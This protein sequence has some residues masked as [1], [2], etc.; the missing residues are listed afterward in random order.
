MPLEFAS[1]QLNSRALLLVAAS[2]ASRNWCADSPNRAPLFQVW[3]VSLADCRPHRQKPLSRCGWS[4]SILTGGCLLLP[5][6][7]YGPIVSWIFQPVLSTAPGPVELSDRCV[8]PPRPSVTAPS[9]GISA[10]KASSFLVPLLIILL[11]I[12][13]YWNSTFLGVLD[14]LNL[15]WR[16]C[17]AAVPD[18]IS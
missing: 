7:I 18:W 4:A 16:F 10:W 13:I 2:R 14:S 1:G 8:Y 6:I 12:Q 17:W 5:M 9:W 15:P 11:R 3:R